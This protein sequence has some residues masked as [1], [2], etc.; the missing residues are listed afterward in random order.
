MHEKAM[1]LQHR[2]RAEGFPIMDTITHIT[3]VVVGDPWK[4]KEASRMLLD[5]HG[6]YIQPLN[7]PTV[8]RGTER[9]RI[10]ITPAHTPE[11]VEHLIGALG[12]V[13]SR[14][15]LPRGEKSAMPSFLDSLDKQQLMD[16]SI[17]EAEH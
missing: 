6:I 16:G 12:D 10:T 8:E 11:M 15:G 9:L 2:L 5:D 4:V 1:K 13:W 14:L 3:P 7:Y 17:Y